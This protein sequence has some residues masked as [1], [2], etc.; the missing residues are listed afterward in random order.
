M[1]EQV[2]NLEIPRRY[3]IILLAFTVL[4]IFLVNFVFLSYITPFASDSDGYL[5]AAKFFRGMAPSIEFPWR[6]LK[7][8]GPFLFAVASYVFDFKPA[9]LFVNS[10]FFLLIGFIVFKIIKLLFSDD[11]Q[12]LLGS[13]LFLSAYPMLE[14]GIAYMTDLAG[15]F[16][17]VLSVYLSLRFLK[18]P[19]WQWIILN[20]LVTSIGFLTKE[21]AAMGSLFFFLCLF[22]VHK[23][24]FTEKIKQ[25]LVYGVLVLVP[26]GIWEAF[27]Y[28]R[29]HYSFYDWFVQNSFG[30]EK[31]EAEKF[32][33]IAKSLA[34]TFLLAWPFVIAG[35]ANLRK[36]SWD[37]GKVLLALILPSF[38][39]LLWPAASSRLF[40]IIGLLL[41]ILA[42]W[43]F[44]SV[45]WLR[46]KYVYIPCLVLIVA[47][48]YFWLVF[49]DRLRIFLKALFNIHY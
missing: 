42:S 5:E 37:A 33:L 30:T 3:F 8:V 23:G 25:L 27:V 13:M 46:K 10:I 21:Y 2:K 1:F 28:L 15:W 49:D 12:A 44:V 26:F 17:F 16:F 11:L 24:K 6:L 22:F 45:G 14:Y 35:F 38:S 43:G 29:F 20:G 18:Q 19:S 31:F 7:P 41:S 32:T 36:M 40:Y 48:N 34:A 4:N 9:F 47:G 39:F